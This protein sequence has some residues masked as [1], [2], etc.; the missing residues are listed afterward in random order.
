MTSGFTAVNAGGCTAVNA[1][2]HTP[3]APP[4][5]QSQ[6]PVPSSFAA[7]NAQNGLYQSDTGRS[8][9]QRSE[10]SP[11]SAANTPD[12]RPF[13][14]SGLAIPPPLN[15]AGLVPQK[16]G[17]SSDDPDSVASGDGDAAGRKGKRR[18]QGEFGSTFCMGFLLDMLH[19]QGCP[20]TPRV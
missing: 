9:P 11:M 5:A 16:R 6:T 20:G 18:K 7:I 15:G 10:A 12:M 19:V 4:H 13:A 17:L 14:P 8:T 1:P 2:S 3:V